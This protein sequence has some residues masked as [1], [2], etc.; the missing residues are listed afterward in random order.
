[1]FMHSFSF[2]RFRLYFCFFIP[3]IYFLFLSFSW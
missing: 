3:A 1:L 2:F